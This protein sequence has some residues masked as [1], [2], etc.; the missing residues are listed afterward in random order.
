MYITS[1]ALA[2]ATGGV[3]DVVGS[4]TSVDG[5]GILRLNLILREIRHTGTLPERVP[6]SESHTEQ[7]DPVLSGTI[8]A[9][10]MGASAGVVAVVATL[11]ARA[12]H[13]RIVRK[14]FS[15]R[16]VV[17]TLIPR[18]VEE[19]NKREKKEVVLEAKGKRGW[20]WFIYR[21]VSVYDK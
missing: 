11:R 1:L 12:R 21:A 16:S 8:A 6:L 9:A 14:G 10:A 4:V 5:V 2:A 3:D 19:E 7:H 15:Q 20:I 13:D 17:Y 18:G